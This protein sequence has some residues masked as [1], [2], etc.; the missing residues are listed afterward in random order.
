[1]ALTWMLNRPFASC[2]QPRLPLL[3]EQTADWEVWF[4]WSRIRASWNSFL[5]FEI[6][7]I[8]IIIIML[9]STAR[10]ASSVNS[11][12][13]D[14]SSLELYWSFKLFSWIY[15]IISSCYFVRYAQ[16]QSAAN[17]CK[18]DFKYIWIMS[19]FM[20]SSNI[21]THIISVSTIKWHQSISKAISNRQ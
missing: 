18:D 1:M 2:C 16:N 5:V 12:V 17:F 11:L 13:S 6:G 8:N 21:N 9:S 3:I 19:T 15:N 7:P 14:A 20:N 4:I 10:K